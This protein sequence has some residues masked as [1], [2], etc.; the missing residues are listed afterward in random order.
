MI[1][2]LDI[3]RIND[4]ELS[5]YRNL[6]VGFVFQTFNLHPTYNAL[7]NVAL[8]LVFAGISPAERIKRAKESLKA[9]GLSQRASH[10]PGELSG[11]EKQ[12]VAIARALVT[13][14]H[15]IL[16][17]EPTG[18]LDS[19][20]GELII[21]ILISLNRSQ[22]ITLLVVTHNPDLARSSPRSLLLRDGIIAKERRS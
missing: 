15:I 5:R 10:Q 1:D 22:G 13:R 17:D 21:E 20:S 8:P 12:R 3:T 14:P 4:R 9:V 18:N 19:Q 11:G 6:Y 2:S 16:A 7:E